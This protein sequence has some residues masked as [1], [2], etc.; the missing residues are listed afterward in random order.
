MPQ[1]AFVPHAVVAEQQRAGR[2]A[3]VAKERLDAAAR[4]VHER[5]R[6]HVY[7][8]VVLSFAP[9]PTRRPLCVGQFLV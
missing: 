8:P 4:L 6:V 9:A 5:V 3:S 2:R 1:D 7:K